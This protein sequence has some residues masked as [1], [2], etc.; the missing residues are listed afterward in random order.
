MDSNQASNEDNWVANTGDSH[1]VANQET[2]E[3]VRVQVGEG[4]NVGK[5]DDD[6]DPGYDCTVDENLPPRSVTK[7]TKQNSSQIRV[8]TSKQWLK[9][10]VRNAEATV[11]EENQIFACNLCSESWEEKVGLLEHL[12]VHH[13]AHKCDQCLKCYKSS[14]DMLN[15]VCSA[16]AEKSGEGDEG[17]FQC[18]KCGKKFSKACYLQRHMRGHS[19]IFRCEK[20]SKRYSRKASLES[21]TCS[22][23]FNHTIA[24]GNLPQIKSHFC[25]FCGA[26]FAQRRLP[27]ASHGCSH[28]RVPVQEMPVFLRSQG[29]P[30]KTPSVL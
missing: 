20:C 22:A 2:A 14:D 16:A 5:V 13:S 8:E 26:G 23:A 29:I 21:H 7:R 12:T 6:G 11:D 9:I 27:D 19:D 24:A 4:S 3:V 15:H 30:P 1:Q 18:E 25:E 28:W 10:A 17:S